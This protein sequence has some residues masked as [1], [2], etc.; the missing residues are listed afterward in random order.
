MRIL[1][2]VITGNIC[3]G[4]SKCGSFLRKYRYRIIDGDDI[5]R[6]SLNEGEYLYNAYVK[7]LGDKILDSDHNIKKEIVRKLIFTEPELKKSIENIAHP[8]VFQSF[9]EKIKENQKQKYNTI[10]IFP[11]LFEIEADISFDYIIFIYCKDHIR[12]KR[13]IKRNLMDQ[14]TAK[15]IMSSQF[16]Q[17]AKI[18]Y[19]DFIIDNSYDFDYTEIQLRCLLECIS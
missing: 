4:K 16:D 14:D 10:C 15:L 3:S 6:E 17:F 19:S 7:I 13:L 12:K 1:S 11:L 8:F 5:V 18:K 2:P 9:N